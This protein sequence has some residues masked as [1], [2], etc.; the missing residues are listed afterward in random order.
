LLVALV[1]EFLI[2]ADGLG[3]VMLRARS[4]LE[5]DKSWAAALLASVLSVAFFALF[6]WF[7]KK[8]RSNWQ[9]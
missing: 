3:Y 8:Y 7:D 5:M 6:S 4:D 1:A 2:G 9:A